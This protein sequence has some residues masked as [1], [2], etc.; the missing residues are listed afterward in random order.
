MRISMVSEH[1]SPLAVL[2]GVDAGG[3]NVH[4]A[5]LSTALARRGH[6]VCVYTRRDDA[7]LPERV[8]L[9]DGVEVV[10]VTA[11][12]ARP[13][14]KDELFPY[15]NDLATGILDD[16]RRRR[17][18]VVHGHFWMSG[19]AA[20]TASCTEHL[21]HG[22]DRVP[23]VQT[24]HALGT[25]K[26]R[27]QGADDTSPAER[28]RVEPWVARTV[29]TV[30]ATCSDEVAE[31]E[32]MG[33]DLAKVSVAPC[34]VDTTL[35]AP[36]GPAEARGRVHRIAV[37]GRLVPRKGTDLV[38]EALAQLTAAG[39]DD[40][41]LVIV[42]G[43]GGASAAED[44]ECLRLAALAKAA[45]VAERVSLRG[46]LAHD[47]LPQFFRSCD[48]VVC[49]PWYEPFGIVPLEAMACGVPVIAARVGG[50]TDSIVDGVTGLHVPPRDPAAIAAALIRIL[51]D[52]PFARALGKAGRERTER[53]YTW[54]R[55]AQLTEEVY[56][57]LLGASMARI[58]PAALVGL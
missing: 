55:V 5:A 28:E 27:H 12:P 4:V 26:R 17:P 3:Q 19:L 45:G 41:E 47:D 34:G 15:M 1:A 13:V 11:G 14:P 49:A 40:V 31:L 30:L 39:R 46:S 9:A 29:D 21:N 50:L 56:D 2:G 25:V 52:A 38:I 23:V 57:R 43:S 8:P 32:A 18:D 36:H 7:A 10:N 44:P 20:L 51:D 24:F 37:V 58:E 16:W 53:L 48:A 22:G 42:G 54:D 6:E 35:L 33:V